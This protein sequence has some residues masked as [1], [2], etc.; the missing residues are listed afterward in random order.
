MQHAFSWLSDHYVA[1]FVVAILTGVVA[2]ATIGRPRRWFL[3]AI[4]TVVVLAVVIASLGFWFFTTVTNILERR[5]N[6]LT[7]A[8]LDAPDVHRV[9]DLRGNIVVLNYWA[10]WCPPCRS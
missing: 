4:D 1:I 10:T 5:T 6:A 8:A 3:W 2:L 7:Y 9:A